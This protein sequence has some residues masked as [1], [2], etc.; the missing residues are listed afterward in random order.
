MSKKNRPSRKNSRSNSSIAEHS[1]GDG[2]LIPPLAKLPKVA[3]ASW[4]DDRLPEML[5]VALLVSSLP[6]NI[7]LNLFRQMARH[8]L[9]FSPV[10]KR[11][12]DI[13]LSGL[14]ELDND[15]FNKLLYPLIASEN[16]RMILSS[17]L[18]LEDFPGKERWQ[19]LIEM[20]PQDDGWALLMRAVARTLDHQS[21]ESTD[22][23][24]LKILCFIAG[25]KLELPTDDMVREYVDY[26]NYGD[27]HKVRP[28]IRATEIA[29]SS[30][31]SHTNGWPGKFWD[32]CLQ[33]TACWP[34]VLVENPQVPNMS[35]TQQ[36]MYE[37]YRSLVEHQRATTKTSSIDAKHDTVFGMGF[38]SLA[39]LQDMLRL[40]ASESIVARAGLR[41]LAELVITMA[42]LMHKNNNGIWQSY[43]VY[44]AGQA[45]LQYLK[46]DELEIC[47]SYVNI[48][49]L[50]ELANEDM[51]E[52]FLPIDLGHWDNSNLR[53]MSDE[54]GVKDVYDEFYTWTSTYSHGHWGAVRD[55]VFTTCG[56]P[57]HR[58]HRIP[59]GIPRTLPDIVPDACRLN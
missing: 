12:F 31:S 33:R 44:G 13:T 48:E 4:R 50:V 23:R 59:R 40:G 26:P 17:I 42:Y 27:Q 18:V 49:T 45:K 6:R 20:T 21:Q 47:P 39:I 41:I 11:P 43:R 34:L 25:D 2:K 32:Q 22:C 52:E 24:W 36:R 54:A 37:V 3:S 14:A 56:N 8:I 1:F 19:H 29:M 53:R 16:C 58:L 35:T 5:W 9:D 10:D 30:A 55:S 15:V 46:L 7:Y 57:L 38:Y 51:W 28:S